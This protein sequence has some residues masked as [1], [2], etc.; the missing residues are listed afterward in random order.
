M[1]N[2]KGLSW[3]ADSAT[4]KTLTCL[5]GVSAFLWWT[6]F[7]EAWL[8]TRPRS[9]L[10]RTTVLF[11]TEDP[12]NQGAAVRS[13]QD[14]IT[15]PVLQQVYPRL[16]E[17][18]EE[19][20]NPNIPLGSSAGRQCE[21]LRRLQIQNKLTA[22]EVELLTDLGFRWH[23]LEDFYKVA[24]FD[25]IFDRLLSYRDAHEGDVSPPKKYAADAEL[26]A[27]VTGLRR[28]G[29]EAV[30]SDHRERLDSIGF[31]WVSQRQCG[32]SFMKQYRAI[33]QQLETTDPSVVWADELNCKWARAQQAA[34]ER[35][36]MSETRQH[37]M[38]QILGSD[39]RQRDL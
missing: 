22:D 29:R 27:W 5:R 6:S 12:S 32:S 11:D 3:Y 16:L 14:V 33:L 8:Q 30:D 36:D 39:W 28:T 13:L 10:G 34:V 17:H 15:S 38:E 19:N 4:M 7:A 23:N 1:T 20:R 18:I 24:D 25:E 9:R 37:F 31:Q 26:G 21:T 2:K 35:K